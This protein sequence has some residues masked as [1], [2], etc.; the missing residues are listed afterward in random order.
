V[1][2]IDSNIQSMTRSASEQARV[3]T[4]VGVGVARANNISE[5]TFATVEKTRA[6]ASSILELD[7]QLSRLIEQFKT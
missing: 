6:A 7:S 2:P 5:H 3:A 4:A 1:D